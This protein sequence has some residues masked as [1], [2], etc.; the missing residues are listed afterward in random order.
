MAVSVSLITWGLVAYEHW[1]T[2]HLGWRRAGVVLVLVG[3]ALVVYG[4]TL[5]RHLYTPPAPDG[6]GEYGA[7]PPLQW[8]VP[9]MLAP[10]MVEWFDRPLA[11]NGGL[12]PFLVA[13]RTTALA[14]LAVL[15]LYLLAL[16]RLRYRL[17][18]THLEVCVDGRVVLAVARGAIIYVQGLAGNAEQAEAERYGP[19]PGAVPVEAPGVPFG[20]G[21][22]IYYNRDGRPHILVL[23]MTPE[24]RE[25]L[26]RWLT[27]HHE[28]VRRRQE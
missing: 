6:T 13:T 28:P 23:A 9:A 11:G 24:L 4:V 17:T 21:A 27:S 14:A 19:I 16:L 1:G 8:V 18:A 10:L 25:A 2:L 26:A 20:Q 3:P 15:V 12:I 5:L 22:R 7:S